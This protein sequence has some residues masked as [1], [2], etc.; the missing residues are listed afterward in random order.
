MCPH[1]A[2]Y[3]SSY[4]YVCALILLYMQ[5]ER[6]MSAAHAFYRKM[7]FYFFCF[8]NAVRASRVCGLRL[9]PGQAVRGPRYTRIL[10][11]CVFLFC[12][13]CVLVLLYV[14]SYWCVCVLILLYICHTA[15][16]LSSSCY[17]C[18]LILLYMCPHTAVCVLIL[19]IHVLILARVP[20]GQVCYTHI[21]Q[22][23]DT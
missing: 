17:I 21:G 1:T 4:C 19:L 10:L 15:I 7:L 6:A 12:C 3:V 5:F 22:Y 9:P 2:M 23:E 13:I 14:S 11:I 20:P 16:H 8:Y 18:V